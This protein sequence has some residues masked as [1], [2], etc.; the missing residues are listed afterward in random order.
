MPSHARN[1]AATSAAPPARE[2]ARLG[3]TARLASGA[4]HA[5]CNALA[6]L[7]AETSYLR[8]E[9]KEDA[10]VSE[11][12][13]ALLAELDRCARLARGLLPPRARHDACDPVV[14]LGQ[15]VHGLGQLLQ[16]TLGSLHQI[17]VRRPEA[18]SLVRA[19]PATLELIVTCLVQ[20]AADHAGGASHVLLEVGAEPAE[21]V[22]ALRM[23]VEGR[24]LGEDVTAALEDPDRAADVV[25]RAALAFVA[26]ALAELGA[27]R[28]AARTAPDAWAMLVHLP[29][30]A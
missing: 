5:L 12:C 6:A 4:A 24:V 8:D 20:Y 23:R 25:S 2:V 21:K 22:V 15:L 14:D 9:R 26:E 13:D 11:S 1:L 7:V 16:E 28:T 30:A 10:L 27:R 17:E 3:A 19:D 18:A 29:A